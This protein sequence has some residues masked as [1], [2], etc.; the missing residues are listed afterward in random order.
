MMRDCLHKKKITPRA[1][2][3]NNATINLS[4]AAM[5]E[6]TPDD[7]DSFSRAGSRSNDGGGGTGD[8]GGVGAGGGGAGGEASS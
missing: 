3:T 1:I 7:R 5:A 2:A 4:S 8:A 6:K